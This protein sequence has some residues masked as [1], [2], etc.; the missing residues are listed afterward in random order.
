MVSTQTRIR[1]HRT[2][3]VRGRKRGSLWAGRPPSPP[4]YALVSA[5]VALTGRPSHRE[6]LL[7]AQSLADAPADTSPLVRFSVG[8]PQ[9]QCTWILERVV[10]RQRRTPQ[11]ASRTGPRE[12]YKGAQTELEMYTYFF[13]RCDCNGTA[14]THL[15]HYT[16]SRAAQACRTYDFV[17]TSPFVSLGC[18]DAPGVRSA[19]SPT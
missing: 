14:P 6:L 12:A 5:R 15:P 19:P 4:L 9:S 17:Q 13:G 11:A 18:L 1:I 10:H 7:L 16:P 2:Y 3:C 8:P